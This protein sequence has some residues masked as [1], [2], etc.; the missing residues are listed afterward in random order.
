MAKPNIET[1]Q[2]KRTISFE[3]TLNLDMSEVINQKNT[4]EKVEAEQTLLRKETEKRDELEHSQKISVPILPQQMKRFLPL[5]F[6]IFAMLVAF[7][8][9]MYFASL[10]VA[11]I[12]AEDNVRAQLAAQVSEQ[13]QSEYNLY[14]TADQQRLIKEELEKRMNSPEIKTFIEQRA[15]QFR[16]DYQDPEGRWYLYGIDSYYYYG[17]AKINRGYD[18]LWPQFLHIFGNFMPLELVAFYLPGILF[19]LTIIPVYFIVRK[20]TNDY[21]ALVASIWWSVHLILL[22][23]TSLGIADT[24]VIN[25]FF[26]LSISWLFVE[27][28]D[29][30]LDWKS[31]VKGIIFTVLIVILLAVFKRTWSG[32]F[33]VVAWILVTLVLVGVSSLISW[34]SS[35]YTLSKNILVF[36]GVAV[37]LLGSYGAYAQY[38]TLLK[39][40]PENLKVYLH[41]VSDPAIFVE[42]PEQQ[43]LPNMFN[44]ITELQKLPF[45]EYSFLAGGVYVLVLS[46]IGVA[47]LVWSFFKTQQ[48][49]PTILYLG[50]MY[51]SMAVVSFQT[52]RFFPYFLIPFIL[53]VGIGFYFV[54]NF[55]YKFLVRSI[56]THSLGMRIII[57]SVLVI[58]LLLPQT[59]ALKESYDAVAS[60]IPAMDDAHYTTAVAIKQDSQ[61]QP[62]NVTVI[63]PW[64]RGH[65]YRAISERDVIAHAQPEAIPNYL[66]YRFYASTNES[67][68]VGL[69]RYLSCSNFRHF[70]MF[71][72]N[73]NFTN[74]T[75]LLEHL[76][77][78]NVSVG[79]QYLQAGGIVKDSASSLV[80]DVFCSP[81]Q[82]Y[83][84][85][86]D[87][88]IS[89]SPQETSKF[90]FV[91]SMADWDI[92]VEEV[93][94][95]ISATDQAT[96]ISYIQQYYNITSD[97]AREIYARFV[98]LQTKQYS[99]LYRMPCQKKGSLF[100]CGAA[101][102]ADVNLMNAMYYGKYPLK[103]FYVD[104]NVSVK[105]FTT[106]MPALPLNA[107][108]EGVAVIYNR[109]AVYNAVVVEPEVADSLYL[110]LLLLKGYGLKHFTNVAEYVRPEITHAAVYKVVW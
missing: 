96:A 11:D 39:Y 24:N 58:V 37:I 62:D 89:T 4:L 55:L 64:D 2:R 13:I 27:L 5:I 20:V 91:R 30:K 41:I 80:R 38:P 97:K 98:A 93:A 1:S 92:R 63:L 65:L 28:L 8:A 66:I 90:N 57:G 109:G 22:Q 77:V 18:S 69:A 3:D 81:H 26:L 110:R 40:A 106:I 86:L 84:V 12:I 31:V 21:G 107:T 79:E 105:D 36:L 60:M 70:R 88:W 94:D 67:V 53:T 76:F 35:R 7:S 82:T 52:V 15:S 42:M 51:V 104:E 59:G 54:Y 10:P 29:L 14:D 34:I 47:S 45:K 46:I 9:R 101:L 48:K 25:L 73:Y 103:F 23:F 100:K 83:I 6:I 17:M 16:K 108:F 85:L 44:Y 74:P 68:S 56:A 19:L 95:V 87:D 99:N 78:S 32:Y 50:V 102:F 71:L 72:T 75:A 33:G 61:L 43:L 49:R